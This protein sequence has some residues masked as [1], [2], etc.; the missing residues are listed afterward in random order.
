MTEYVAGFMFNKH[1][2]LL[3]VRKNRPAWQAGRYNGIGGHIEENE[4]PFA[5]MAREFREE[6]GMETTEDQWQ[7]FAVLSGAE[8]KV[9]FFTTTVDSFLSAKSTTDEEIVAIWPEHIT[10]DNSIPNLTWLVPLA[11]SMEFDRANRFHI[12]EVY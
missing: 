12:Q 1:G 11:K 2:G 9:H 4:T 10:V 6:T 5:A 8:F 7:M 3:L